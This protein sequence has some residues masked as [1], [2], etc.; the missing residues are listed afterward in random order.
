[1]AFLV[2]A[3]T[4]FPRM[5]LAVPQYAFSA[6]LGTNQEQLNDF[7]SDN[8]K[9]LIVGGLQSNFAEPFQQAQAHVQIEARAAAA[10]GAQEKDGHSSLLPLWVQR[11]W[12][13]LKEK[14]VQSLD[15]AGISE[16]IL[17]RYLQDQIELLEQ[18]GDNG[19]DALPSQEESRCPHL[20]CDA[21]LPL[22]PSSRNSL[23]SG[24]CGGT[25]DL[26]GL[27]HELLELQES[28][29]KYEQAW[30]DYGLNLCSMGGA[31]CRDPLTLL[32][33]T[34]RPP[35]LNLNVNFVF[36]HGKLNVACPPLISLWSFGLNLNFVRNDRDKKEK[37][38][39][40]NDEQC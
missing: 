29:Q 36:S 31:A 30:W 34:L 37:E 15:A 1:M 25:S 24:A 5:V 33:F 20:H 11:R 4:F 22:V 23:S 3:V 14:N 39:V 8:V 12:S 38:L 18:R 27:M 10:D 6:P 7:G 35:L 19:P 16:Q 32:S 26:E 28:Q 17:E 21:S 2:N 13:Y 9:E 40:R